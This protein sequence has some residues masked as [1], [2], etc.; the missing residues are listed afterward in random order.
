MRGGRPAFGRFGWCVLWRRDRNGIG[1]AAQKVQDGNRFTVVIPSG[2]QLMTRGSWICGIAIVVGSLLS[3]SGLMLAQ[4]PEQ[5][6]TGGRPGR[7]QLPQPVYRVAQQV[8][9]GD[10]QPN[11]A[12][13]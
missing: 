3:V 11:E 1:T 13:P 10:A 8:P 9:N 7:E 5:P 2:E 12:A 6:R 4:S